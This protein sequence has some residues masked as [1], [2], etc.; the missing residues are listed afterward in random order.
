[1]ATQVAHASLGAYKRADKSIVK[2]W[3]SE[4]AKKIIVKVRSLRKLKGIYKKVK[5]NKIPC[6]LVKDAGMTQ[7]RKGAITALGIGPA[8]DERV[9]KITKKLKLL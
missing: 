3:E 7:L 2:K 6:F 9:D 5:K 1:L 4:G 8:K